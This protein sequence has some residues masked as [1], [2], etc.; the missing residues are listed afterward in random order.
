MNSP[1]GKPYC[2]YGDTAYAVN[3]DVIG[4]VKG[5]RINPEEVKFNRQM[6]A[7]RQC[8]EWSF[9]KVVQIFAFDPR[10][11]EKR[12]TISCLSGSTSLWEL[13]W[14]IVTLDCMAVKRHSTSGYILIHWKNT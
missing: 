8:V 9:N 13:S 11:Q 10:L 4:P 6:S 7:V 1:N 5:I 2:L 12:K 3:Q 14:P